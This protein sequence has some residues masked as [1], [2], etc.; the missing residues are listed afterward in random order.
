MP[1]SDPNCVFCRI[2]A[3]VIPCFKIGEDERTVA[4]LDINPVNPG[5][6]LVVTKAHAPT[7]M[8]AGDGDLVA[9]LPMARRVAD[10]VAQ[11]LRPDGINLLQANGPGAAQS[12]PH[13][14]L[15]VIPR[16]LDDGLVMNWE[17]RPGDKAEL[18]ALAERLRNAMARIP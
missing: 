13:F 11:E 8:A 5:H 1:A 3:G 6:A 14:H 4:F 10:A 2:L 15:H 12:V 18:A 7:L 17:L 9:V 16:R